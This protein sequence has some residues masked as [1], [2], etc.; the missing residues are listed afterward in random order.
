MVARI[1]RAN[2][3]FD[4]KAERAE[5]VIAAADALRSELIA[6]REEDETAYGLVVEA[7]G[8][9]PIDPGRKSAPDVA[10]PSGA[11]RRRRGSAARRV[12]RGPR[13]TARARRGRPRQ[14]APRERRDVRGGVRARR[15]GSECRKRPHQSPLSARRRIR[16]HPRSGAHRIRTRSGVRGLNERRDRP[17]LDSRANG[18]SRTQRDERQRLDLSVVHL[19][20][21]HPPGRSSRARARLPSTRTTRRCTTDCRRRTEN[22]RTSAALRPTSARADSDRVPGSTARRDARRIARGSRCRRDRADTGRSR[23][24]FAARR[25]VIHA[26][27]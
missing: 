18:G 4:E 14:R 20:K 26:G 9:S 10:A 3:A 8:S 16:P 13:A 7:D 2:P 27:G 15:V 22:R 19:R 17:R 6:A 24:A 11:R 12:A 21:P 23:T 5:A 1:T 25:P